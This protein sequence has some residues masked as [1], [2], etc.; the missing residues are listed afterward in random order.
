[1]VGLGIGRDSCCRLGVTRMGEGVTNTVDTRGERV[2]ASVL[3]TSTAASRRNL[4]RQDMAC[5]LSDP[6]QPSALSSLRSGEGGNQTRWRCTWMDTLTARCRLSSY[7]SASSH[8]KLQD[9]GLKM[10]GSGSAG[11]QSRAST[12]MGAWV[13][14]AVCV[15]GFQEA[16]A[17]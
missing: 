8:R 15:G 2:T 7:S 10:T 14:G 3:G 1:M 9:D 6:K 12:L 17:Q 16:A 5:K 13:C 4:A 11:R